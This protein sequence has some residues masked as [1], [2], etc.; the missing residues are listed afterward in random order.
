MVAAITGAGAVGSTAFP[1][2]ALG[3]LAVLACV[4]T[5][6][7]ASAVFIP[8]LLALMLSYA[9]SPV[10]SSLHRLRIPRAVSAAV[11][12]LGILG[13]TGSLLY[14]LSDDAVALIESLPQSAL[15]RA[16]FSGHKIELLIDRSRL[17]STARSGLECSAA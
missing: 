7:W 14:S 16:R 17:P 9:L 13:G 10:V 3:V 2:A 12:L 11:L 4:F 8:V 15:Y 6:K 1:N 5:L